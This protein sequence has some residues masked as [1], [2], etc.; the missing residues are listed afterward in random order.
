M[1]NIQLKED[2]KYNFSQVIVANS[3]ARRG[4]STAASGFHGTS[5]KKNR[6]S[7]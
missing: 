4:Q 7:G 5:S 1:E 3:R 2:Q 6:G